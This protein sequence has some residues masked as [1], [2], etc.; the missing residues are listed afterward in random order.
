MYWFLPWVWTAGW[1]E[2]YLGHGQPFIAE[3]ADDDLDAAAELHSEAFDQPWSGDELGTL[4]AQRGS[5]GFVARLPGLPQSPPLGFV[6]ARSVEGE[7]EILTIT[8]ARRNR[9]AGVGRMLMDQVLQKLHAERAHSLFLEV[10]EENQAA[11]RLYKRLRFE[12]VGRRPAYYQ[13][14]DGRRTSA[15]TLKRSLFAAR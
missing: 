3:L 5:F 1:L 15:L 2:T 10:D 6:L 14:P 7:A 11:L 9:R 4:L 13:H 12:E 8:V